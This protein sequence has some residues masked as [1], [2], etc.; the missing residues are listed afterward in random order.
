MTNTTTT[1]LN[2]RPTTTRHDVQAHRD[3]SA[4]QLAAVLDGLAG[5]FD[6]SSRQSPNLTP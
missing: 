4:R 5:A 1:M 3:R 2:A 6:T